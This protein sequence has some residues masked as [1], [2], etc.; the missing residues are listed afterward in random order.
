M[1]QT[2]PTSIDFVES[3]IVLKTDLLKSHVKSII[4]RISL[5]CRVFRRKRQWGSTRE[6]F[7]NRSQTQQ[8]S[9][10]NWPQN[11][12]S[13]IGID[14]TISIKYTVH[15]EILELLFRTGFEWILFET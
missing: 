4:R 2:L 6:I 3:I 7:L 12:V 11:K 13:I 15:N 1:K 9:R 5:Y 10:K 8:D 14:E